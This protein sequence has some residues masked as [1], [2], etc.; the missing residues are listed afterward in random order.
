MKSK[1]S[2]TYEL[3]E[4]D[5]E[6]KEWGGILCQWICLNKGMYESSDKKN[7]IFP[8]YSFRERPNVGVMAAAAIKDGWFALEECWAEK[9][10][11]D[12]TFDGR[13]DLKIWRGNIQYQIESKFTCDSF[14][15][16]KNKISS[17]HKDAIKDAKNHR[18]EE[19]K[20]AM[21]F[22][23][24]RIEEKEYEKVSFE[25]NLDDLI[26]L[27]RD[28]EPRYPRFLGAV[29]PGKVE[30]K[31]GDRHD[32]ISSINKVS[33]GIIVIGHLVE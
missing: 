10:E 15:K 3:N 2:K 23:V 7:G 13:A 33:Y 21:T 14:D 31:T 17:R 30:R 28:F 12:S 24:P 1:L 11:V 9:N 29:F 6:L 18:G 16:L 26:D 32:T 20:I 22:I 19:K 4:T 8:P 25:K 5:K 27:S